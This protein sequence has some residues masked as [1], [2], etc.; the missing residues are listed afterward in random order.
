MLSDHQQL[1]FQMGNE[2]LTLPLL[3]C[4]YDVVILFHLS[5]SLCFL[6]CKMGM[7]IPMS[8][9]PSSTQQLVNGNGFL[10]PSVS[11]N[12]EKV[13]ERTSLRD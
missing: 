12:N 11:M 2:I 3:A 9:I 6:I 7:L 8:N 4:L 1:I 10:L 13:W 5:L